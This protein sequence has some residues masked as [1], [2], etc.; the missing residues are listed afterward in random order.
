MSQSVFKN[1]HLLQKV[2][3]VSL[4]MISITGVIGIQIGNPKFFINAIITES[5]FITLTGLSVWK[6]RYTLI[7]NII[8][9]ALVI[10]GNT[11]APR[12]I[13]IMTSGEPFE[14]AVVLIIGGYILQGLLLVTNVLVLKNQNHQKLK[15]K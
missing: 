14:N 7:P 12:H 6:L 5:A 10:V 13:E 11:A 3:V 15:I 9:S 2:I 8:I 1:M 4:I